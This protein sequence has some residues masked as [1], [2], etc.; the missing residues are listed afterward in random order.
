MKG[1]KGFT[2]RSFVKGSA[3]AVTA[4]LVVRQGLASPGGSQAGATE[5]VPHRPLGKTGA[6]VSCLG[7][8]GYH[9]GSIKKEKESFELVAR[10][11]GGGVNFFDNCWEYPSGV[12][13]ERVRAAFDGK[14]SK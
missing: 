3:A 11:L 9:L 5:E 12:S 4:S 7:V 1:K 14:P 8:G 10:E 6:L 13:E 2:R